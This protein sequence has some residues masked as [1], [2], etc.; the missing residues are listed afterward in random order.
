[1]VEVPFTKIGNIRGSTLGWAREETD[2]PG[3]GKGRVGDVHEKPGEILGLLRGIWVIDF[4]EYI[5]ERY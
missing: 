5:E 3:L 4:R 1:M 2:E